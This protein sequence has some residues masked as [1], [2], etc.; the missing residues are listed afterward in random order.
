M[1]LAIARSF[2]EVASAPRALPKKRAV[3]APIARNAVHMNMRV[4]HQQRNP[5]QLSPPVFNDGG[6]KPFAGR[7]PFENL[8]HTWRYD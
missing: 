1:G 6:W 7:D 4:E 5:W 2:A 8:R 3:A